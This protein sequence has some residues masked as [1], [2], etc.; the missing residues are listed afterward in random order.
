MLFLNIHFKLLICILLLD[1]LSKYFAQSQGWVI[2]NPGISFGVGETW[3]TAVKGMALGMVILG[4]GWLTYLQLQRQQTR[5]FSCGMSLFWS[6]VI[7]NLLDR[8]MVGGVR[9][10]LPLPLTSLHNNVADYAIFIGSLSWIWFELANSEIIH[11]KRY[12]SSHFRRSR[13]TGN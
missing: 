8:I 4:M 1:Q 9:D 3:P 7:G 11:F 5:Y 13:S 10:W 6:G 2:I 12:V